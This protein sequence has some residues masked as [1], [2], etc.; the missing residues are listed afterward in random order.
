MA[1]PLRQRKAASGQPITRGCFGVAGVACPGMFSIG[2]PENPGELS[3]SH[4]Q[5]AV[6]PNPKRTRSRGKRGCRTGREQ[7]PRRKVPAAKGD[8][9]LTHKCA[10]SRRGKFTVHVKAMKKRLRRSFKAVAEWCRTHRH[11]GADQQQAILNAKLR[12]HY[13]HYGIPT[14]DPSRWRFYRDVRRSW[15]SGSNAGRGD[16]L[17]AGKSTRRSY[18]ASAATSADRTPVGQSSESSLR[19][20]LR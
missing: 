5:G 16:S 1:T 9:R 3:I 2:L 7:T 18:A 17:S 11:D 13:Q 15:R 19:N 14:N 10:L 4:E 6:L 20:P 8:R 12:G